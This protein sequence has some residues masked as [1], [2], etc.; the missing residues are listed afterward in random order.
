MSKL[1]APPPE[2]NKEALDDFSNMLKEQINDSNTHQHPDVD[3][4]SNESLDNIEQMPNIN[5]DLDFQNI[6]FDPQKLDMLNNQSK[7]IGDL[8]DNNFEEM[9]QN[10]KRLQIN[11]N[12]RKNK[13][14]NIINYVKEPLLVSI[15]YLVMSSPKLNQLLLRLPYT[16]TPRK[17]LTKCGL[18]IKSIIIGIMF[19][20]CKLFI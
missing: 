10:I 9:N 6:D 15:L 4:I 17:R 2:L 3:I 19:F 1:N 8:F 7:K 18:F 20:V 12:N 5:N 11:R 16:F 13:Y 14:E